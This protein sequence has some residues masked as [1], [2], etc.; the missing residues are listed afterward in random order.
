MELD[1]SA[2]LFSVGN[3]GLHQT[4]ILALTQNGRP[5]CT[6]A[7]ARLATKK[8]GGITA[9]AAR[10]LLPSAIRSPI[11]FLVL[12]FWVKMQGQANESA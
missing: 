7:R 10:G 2:N 4:K 6:T 11:K 5:M 12:I 1:P 8:N 3:I 9:L